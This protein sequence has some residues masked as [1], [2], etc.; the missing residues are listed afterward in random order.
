M[1]K[2]NRIM[3]LYLLGLLCRQLY[4]K[5]LLKGLQYLKMVDRA[6]HITSAAPTDFIEWRGR[7]TA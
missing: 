4:N 3:A 2:V 5:F 1:V 6:H 7:C